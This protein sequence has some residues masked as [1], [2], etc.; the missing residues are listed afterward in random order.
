VADEAQTKHQQTSKEP[1]KH[2][3]NNAS[4]RELMC[5]C[6]L[7]VL[8]S[9]CFTNEASPASRWAICRAL[10]Q[11]TEVTMVE[12]NHSL[13]RHTPL[14]L[15]QQMR[16]ATTTRAMQLSRG[17]VKEALKRQAVRLCEVDGKDITSWALVYIEDHPELIAEA[18]HCVEAWFAR[19][20][21][22]KRAQRA[23]A[24]LTSA[25]QTAEPHKSITSTVQNSGA[26]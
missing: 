20:V 7:V 21:F 2:Q 18:K 10:T 12:A 15:A 17:A 5:G 25:A 8:S 16:M 4:P 9:L 24:N 26:K 14:T 13:S 22:G 3:T 1:N 19:G 23:F 11:T 6:L